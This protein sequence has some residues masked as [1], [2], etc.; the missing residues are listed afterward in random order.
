MYKRQVQTVRGTLHLDGV[1]LTV[2]PL[3]GPPSGT[4]VE[5]ETDE[6]VGASR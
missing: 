6:R 2:T 5:L 1:R 4:P 3:A